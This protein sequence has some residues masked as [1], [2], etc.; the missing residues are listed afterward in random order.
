MKCIAD[1][2][3]NCEV[4]AILVE[5]GLG[6]A[7]RGVPV[8]AWTVPNPMPP[9]W[10][11]TGATPPGWSRPR[12]PV[13]AQDAST[14]WLPMQDGEFSAVASSG[15][16]TGPEKATIASRNAGRVDKVDLSGLA[17]SMSPPTV[18]QVAQ[19]QIG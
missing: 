7:V 15:L 13:Y 10:D 11:G 3:A 4:I 8:G 17:Q 9:S 14:A 1:T 2:Q 5:K 19:A 12:S 6:G 18:I 16:L